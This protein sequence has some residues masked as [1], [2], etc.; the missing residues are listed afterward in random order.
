MEI[1]DAIREDRACQVLLLNYKKGGQP[2]WNQFYL[3]PIRDDQGHVTHYIGIQS[4]VTDEVQR[5]AASSLATGARPRRLRAA[6]PFP[7]LQARSRGRGL[8]CSPASPSLDPPWHWPHMRLLPPAAAAQARRPAR[9]ARSPTWRSRSWWT[10]WSRW[11]RWR[12][13]R[14]RWCGTSCR[15]A[16]GRLLLPLAAAGRRAPPA[17]QYLEARARLLLTRR[18]PLQEGHCHSC[19]PLHSSLLQPLMKVQQ[20]F[21]LADPSLPDTPIVHASEL[22]LQ[23]TGYPR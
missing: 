10:R 14:R 4:D 23:L 15:W 11:W 13:A 6:P 1:R 12:R 5:S 3:A 16:A 21:V 2:F 7:P 8:A 17:P 22:F 18:P 19:S 9:P 20:S